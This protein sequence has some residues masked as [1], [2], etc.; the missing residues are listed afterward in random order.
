[1]SVFAMP[2]AMNQNMIMFIMIV[3]KMKHMVWGYKWDLHG[4]L[5]KN[6]RFYTVT[7]ASSEPNTQ[8]VLT[9]QVSVE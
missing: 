3:S 9:L 4:Q 7:L 1:M 2:K 6:E 8:L 5:M